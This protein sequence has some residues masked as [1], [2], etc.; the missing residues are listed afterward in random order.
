[1]NRRYNMSDKGLVVGAKR[2]RPDAADKEQARS[3][4]GRTR[5]PAAAG[6][7]RREHEEPDLGVKPRLDVSKYFRGEAN[8][9]RRVDDKKLKSKIK[10]SEHAARS[11]AK[12][13]AQAE[14]LLTEEAGYV[15]PRAP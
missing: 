14:L 12:A 8:D 9:A 6:A 2:R 5:S 13:A 11:S 15:A 7:G 4:H 3:S 10:R 1:M